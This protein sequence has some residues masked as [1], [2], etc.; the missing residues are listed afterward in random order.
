MQ[1]HL[2]LIESLLARSPLLM[3]VSAKALALAL[4]CLA[5]SLNMGLS[6]CVGQPGDKLRSCRS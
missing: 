2:T 1:L 5:Y 3:R 6:T 4:T